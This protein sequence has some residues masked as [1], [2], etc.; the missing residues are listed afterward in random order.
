VD[1]LTPNIVG[2]AVT[3]HTL[4]VELDDGR[5][6]SAPLT[7]YPRLMH[8]DTQARQN[9]QVSGGHIYW[10]D[11]D[12]DVGARGLLLGRRSGESNASLRA[13]LQ[14]RS[15][16]AIAKPKVAKQSASASR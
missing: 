13:W 1:L 14:S 2:A 16:Q 3:A 4:T 9:F 6:L 5:V 15:T 8:A 12:E 7:W 11:L 10:P